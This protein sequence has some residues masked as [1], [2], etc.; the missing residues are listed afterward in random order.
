MAHFGYII[1]TG[2]GSRRKFFHP[3]RKVFISL[4]EPHPKPVSK[5]Y[6]IKIVLAHLKE[7]GF[8]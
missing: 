7:E 5:Q 2:D 6:A 8:L 3:V 4:H 1:V